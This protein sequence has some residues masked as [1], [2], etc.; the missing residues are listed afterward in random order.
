MGNSLSTKVTSFFYSIFD[1]F[2]PSL[3][4]RYTLPLIIVDP[5]LAAVTASGWFSFQ[6]GKQEI[7]DL[8]KQV[9]EE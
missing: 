1:R 7:E 9:S 5:L 8:I 2:M 3:S 6:A 4:I